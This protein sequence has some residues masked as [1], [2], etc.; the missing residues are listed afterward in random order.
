[1]IREWI[2]F[3]ICLGLGG[4]LALG[5]VLHAPDLWSVRNAGL[6][7]LLAGIAI[8]IFVQAARALWCGVHGI[9]I[10]AMTR[11]LDVVGV[12]SVQVLADMLISHYLQG[13]TQAEA[14]QQ[15]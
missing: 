7:G 8:Y 14:R 10:L 4:H 1:M 12:D 15:E 3:A 6:N 2:I 13:F 9:C 5:I 11:K